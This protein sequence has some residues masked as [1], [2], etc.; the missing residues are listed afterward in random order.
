MGVQFAD[1]HRRGDRTSGPEDAVGCH[2][3]IMACGREGSNGRPTDANP[4]PF[5]LTLHREVSRLTKQRFAAWPTDRVRRVAVA[6]LRPFG[7]PLE[8]RRRC[9]MDK[10]SLPL[11]PLA[12]KNR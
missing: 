5:K 3:G 10:V 2:A 8:R 6:Y 9:R 1:S 7:E 4:G 12:V 11:A